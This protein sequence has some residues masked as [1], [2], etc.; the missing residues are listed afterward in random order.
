MPYPSYLTH[1][2]LER[3]AF[4]AGDG[5]IA[6]LAETAHNLEQENLNYFNTHDTLKAQAFEA[7]KL[8]GLS[9]DVQ[10][11]MSSLNAQLSTMQN[12]LTQ[13][14]EL[15]GTCHAWL[16][17][18]QTKTVKGRRDAAQ[19]LSTRMVSQGLGYPRH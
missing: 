1:E 15:L 11:A 5:L 13:A 12:Q 18:D 16:Q 14:T 19:S 17:G 8:E 4:L 3:R 10:A 9:E 7:G 6:S 2:E